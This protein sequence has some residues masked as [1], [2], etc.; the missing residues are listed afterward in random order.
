MVLRN[1]ALL[2]VVA[3]LVPAGSAAQQT[4]VEELQKELEQRDEII[5]ELLERVEALERRTG[6]SQGSSAEAADPQRDDPGR[7]SQDGRSTEAG[8]GELRPDAEAAERAPGTV[9]IDEAA[10]ERALERSL[11]QA[12]AL[13]LRPGWM[14]V[15]PSFSYARNEDATPTFVRDNGRTLSG[16]LERNVDT[17]TADLSVRLGLPWDA[18]LE[19]SGPYRWRRVD[20]VTR[21][22]FSPVEASE[23]TGT[24]FGDLR[25]G[26]AK[27][28]LREAVWR[29]DLIGRVTWDTDTGKERDDGIALG[30]GFNELRTSLTAIKRQD[31][32]VFVGRLAHEH[33]FESDNVRPGAITSGN[34]GGFIALSPQTSLRLLLS[35]AR[36]QETRVSG[37]TIDGSD[38]TVAVFSVGG[39]TLLG[40]GTLLNLSAGIGLTNDADDFSVTLSVPIRFDSPIF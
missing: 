40:P 20:N 32:V 14:E 6:T 38:R 7:V 11:T 29:P 8:Q 36:Q 34:L 16:Q 23:Q 21:A 19:V 33:T 26:M 2:C 31:P 4:T 39:S 35:A 10:A 22:G 5:M 24:G 37:A 15:E 27:T 1:Y 12:G 28:L 25:V 30:G 9:V 3:L 17:L 13:L 18:Q